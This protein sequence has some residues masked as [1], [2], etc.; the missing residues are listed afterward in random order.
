MAVQIVRALFREDR[1]ETPPVRAVPLGK[2]PPSKKML[3]KTTWAG[4]VR[5]AFRPVALA[6][7]RRAQHAAA[8]CPHPEVNSLDLCRLAKAG[9]R[10]VAVVA[11][12]R[13]VCAAPVGDARRPRV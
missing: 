3:P 11:E 7:T 1:S 13:A 9:C 12:A 8:A 10:P 5:Q 4:R 2:G 6:T